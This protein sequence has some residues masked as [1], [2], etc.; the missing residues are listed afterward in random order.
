LSARAVGA[1]F[2]TGLLPVAASDTGTRCVFVEPQR[3]VQLTFSVSLGKVSNESD[4]EPVTIAGHPGYLATDRSSF[5]FDLSSTSEPDGKGTLT[6]VV[7]AG[8]AV[9]TGPPSGAQA[10]AEAVLADVV[11]SHF[12]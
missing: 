3:R 5:R 2:G 1:H 11:E 4:G 10:K 8:P 9:A 7:A 12:S 6:L